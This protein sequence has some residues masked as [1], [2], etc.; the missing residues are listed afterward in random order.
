MT[1][2][3]NALEP[4][5][6]TD[7][8]IRRHRLATLGEPGHEFVNAND[9]NTAAARPGAAAAGVDFTSCGFRNG[10]SQSGGF[11]NRKIKFA[12]VNFCPAYGSK[13]FFLRLEAG[14]V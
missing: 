5:N 12:R 13:K 1:V 3:R 9:Q 8:G 4:G 11:A 2:N 14:V 7:D 6:E 10:I